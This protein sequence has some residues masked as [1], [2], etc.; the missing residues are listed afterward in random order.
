VAR[1]GATGPATVN[2]KEV[3]YSKVVF[4]VPAGWPVI[5]LAANPGRCALFNVHAVYLGHQGPNAVCPAQALG[6]TE[7]VQVEPLD[8]E[9][10]AHLLPSAATATIHGQPAAV[11]PGTSATLS[12]VA[13][14]P[15]LGV[16]VTATYLTDPSTANRIV[17]SVQS[18]SGGS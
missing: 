18:A 11:Q 5:D 9:S 1:A 2:W 7:A 10:Q 8:A 14:F 17:G 3:R 15:R 12:V 6:R 16:T 4:A 13:S